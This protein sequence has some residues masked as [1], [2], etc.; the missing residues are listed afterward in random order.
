M[1]SCWFL[2][3]PVSDMLCFLSPD[4]F[5]GVSHILI[6]CSSWLFPS[7]SRG[8]GGC[9]S[10]TVSVWYAP[11]CFLSRL[12]S[13]CRWD[14]F[15]P[16]WWSSRIVRS[17]SFPKRIPVTINSLLESRLFSC[18]A[19]RGGDPLRVLA[20]RMMNPRRVLC[21]LGSFP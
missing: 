13:L 2:S 9:C 1:L 4:L 6:Q 21:P 20:V 10:L 18:V 8:L 14:D 3:S 15:I 16:E 19:C 12:M 11:M 17:R 5:R 7:T